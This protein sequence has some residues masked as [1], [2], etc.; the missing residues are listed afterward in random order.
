MQLSQ[1]LNWADHGGHPPCYLMRC[2]EGLGY[3]LE[4]EVHHHIEPVIDKK[5]TPYRFDSLDQAEHFLKKH[6]IHKAELILSLPYDE[7]VGEAIQQGEGQQ[8]IPLQF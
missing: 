4:V 3:A 1:F 2:A 8:T 6:G 5:G 7:M